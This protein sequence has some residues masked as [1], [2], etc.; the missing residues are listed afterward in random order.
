MLV[1]LYVRPRRFRAYGANAQPDFLF[2]RVHLDNLELVF[3]TGFQRECSAVCV[4]S[5]GVMAQALDSIGN[6]DDR[7]KAGEPQNLAV[8]DVPNLM[9]FEERLPHIRLKL[10]HPERETT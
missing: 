1:S 6:L 3:L 10:L 4:G 9:L 5:F 7:T 8:N 2:F